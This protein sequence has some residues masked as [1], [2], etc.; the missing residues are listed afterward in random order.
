MAKCRQRT[1]VIVNGEDVSDFVSRVDIPRAP[2]EADLATITF[3][4]DPLRV[5]DEGKL[6]ITINTRE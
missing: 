6:I 2:D 3:F 5:D 1:Q 4:T